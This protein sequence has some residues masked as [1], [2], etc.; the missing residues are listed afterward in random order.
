MGI[1]IG[2]FGTSLLAGVFPWFVGELVVVGSAVLLPRGTLPVL[3]LVCAAGQLLGKTLVF[4]IARWAPDR[5]PERG[6]KAL[7]R[8]SKV[9][10]GSK[11]MPITVF[12]SAALSIPPF[13]L[14]TLA[15]GTL[16]VPFRVFVT[17]SL[18]GT[19]LRYGAVAWSA[20]FLG[21]GVT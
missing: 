19:L 3:I 11:A 17:A 12:S 16:G 10:R 4:S 20:A 9:G 18:G 13:Y 14:V 6:R 21:A 15:C 1:L 8:A 2:A 5:L 7:D